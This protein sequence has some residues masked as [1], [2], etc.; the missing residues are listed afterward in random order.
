M[1]IPGLGLAK[2]ALG[3]AIDTTAAVAAVPGRVL[4][5]IGEV[6]QLVRKVSGTV[7][8]VD[9]IVRKADELVD[10]TGQVVADAEK[11]VD[12]VRAITASAGDVAERATQVVAT[13]GQTAHTAN[14]LIGIYEP[15]AKQA[16]PLAAR[17]V[18]ELS[19]HEVE[20]AIKLV[21]ELP[22][23][24]EHL[25]NDILPILAT[26]DRVGPEVHQLLE[27]TNDVRQ[28]ILGIPGFGF[29]RRRGEKKEDEEGVKELENG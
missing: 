21:D 4:N 11:A 29:M 17:F 28:A 18:N 16:Q 26:L 14:E 15:I 19:A 1:E 6:E 7:D 12:A 2:Q 24:T 25:I 23:L 20:A 9:G 22:V 5:L 27:V 3:T 13:A 8:A 10:R